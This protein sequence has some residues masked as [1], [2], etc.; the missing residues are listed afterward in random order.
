MNR[1]TLIKVLGT[2]GTIIAILMFVSLIEVARSNMSGDSN[3]FI[4]PLVTMINCTIWS[5]YAYMK[6][7]WFLF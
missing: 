2:S 7:E 1:Q 5:T 6:K 3:I 4:Q